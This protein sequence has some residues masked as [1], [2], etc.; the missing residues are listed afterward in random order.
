MAA[1]HAKKLGNGRLPSATQP[2]HASPWPGLPLLLSLSLSL[3]LSLPE[4]LG[5]GLPLRLRGRAGFWHEVCAEGVGV[6]RGG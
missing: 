6:E 2:A 1:F 5:L 4:V 3:P